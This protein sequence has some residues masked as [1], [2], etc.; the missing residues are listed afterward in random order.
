MGSNAHDLL[1]EVL[2]VLESGADFQLGPKGR[3]R[4][5]PKRIKDEL[6]PPDPPPLPRGWG[7]IVGRRSHYFR[8]GE[9]RSLCGRIGFYFGGR[10]DGLHDSPDNCAECRR[11]R[12]RTP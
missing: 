11:R 8:Q 3:H 1:R 5:L 6:N 10:D 9:E 12:L 2:K 4:D 7:P